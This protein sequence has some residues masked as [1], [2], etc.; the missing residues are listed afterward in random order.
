MPYRIKLGPQPEAYVRNELEIIHQ[1]SVR[2]FKYI[3]ASLEEGVI[4]LHGRCEYAKN[5]LKVLEA[6]EPEDFDITTDQYEAIVADLAKTIVISPEAWV[7]WIETQPPSGVTLFF[8]LY[9][10]LRPPLPEDDA[11]EVWIFKLTAHVH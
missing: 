1:G 5:K 10:E 6:A 8:S 7:C 11:P 9:F 2:F 4:N 3:V